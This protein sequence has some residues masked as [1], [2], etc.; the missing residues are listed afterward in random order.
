M[1][2]VEILVKLYETKENA[3]AKLQKYKFVKKLSFLEFL[4]VQ[5]SSFASR[6]KRVYI[7]V[8]ILVILVST[9]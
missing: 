5:D 1:E 4:K 8:G 7:A 6:V 3:L 2:E 9:Q